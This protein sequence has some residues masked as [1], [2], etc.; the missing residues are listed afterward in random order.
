MRAARF[1]AR[2]WHTA[3]LPRNN[4]PVQVRQKAA[5]AIALLFSSAYIVT[6]VRLPGKLC[7]ERC[8]AFD[9][10][11]TDMKSMKSIAAGLY[12][13]VAVAATVT[14]TVPAH[15][16]PLTLP[17]RLNPGDTYRLV[18]ETSVTTAATSTDINFYNTFV[19]DFANNASLNPVLASLG[20]TWTTIASTAAVDAQDNTGTNL[21]TDGAGVSIYHLNHQIVAT[22]NA[23]LWDGSIANLIRSETGGFDAAPVVWTGSTAAGVESIGLGLGRIN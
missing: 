11:V 1:R 14:M 4:Y 15:S 18:F 3:D 20:T 2:C 21:T 12:M 23:D 7:V 17:S 6:G 8:R 9:G 16:M 13:A 5:C 22:G 19:N 10:E